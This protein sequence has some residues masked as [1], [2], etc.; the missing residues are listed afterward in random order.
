MKNIYQKVI[1]ILYLI[2]VAGLSF[3]SPLYKYKGRIV[4]IS[5]GIGG[6]NHN[7]SDLE[8]G[9]LWSNQ[10]DWFK[11]GYIFFFINLLFILLFYFFRNKPNPDVNSPIFKRKLKRELKVFAI[12]IIAFVA[13]LGFIEVFNLY[14]ENKKEK[15]NEEIYER[16]LWLSDH[17][18]KRPPI[19]LV[20]EYGIPIKKRIVPKPSDVLK[21]EQQSKPI[22]PL[23]EYGILIKKSKP[24]F[25]PDAFLKREDSLEILNKKEQPNKKL[26]LDR[27][28]IILENANKKNEFFYPDDYLMSKKY[29]DMIK[30]LN[31]ERDKLFFFVRDGYTKSVFLFLIIELLVLYILRYS[32]YGVRSLNN[33]LKEE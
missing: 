5:D 29:K 2:V 23:D 32:Y 16:N 12:G 13:F 20:D 9:S 27:A 3:Y 19:K 30:E 28:N 7:N 6:Y 21:K 15:I 24:K 31:S 22:T 4:P 26:N 1:A 18:S 10:V 17:I 8:F 11:F 14:Q 33:Y 25:D